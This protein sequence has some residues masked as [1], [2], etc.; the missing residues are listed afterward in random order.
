MCMLTP[1]AAL[2]LVSSRGQ[3]TATH[4]GGRLCGISRRGRSCIGP[5]LQA[6]WL[7]AGPSRGSASVCLQCWE[8]MGAPG[9]WPTLELQP[10]EPPQSA[11]AQQGASHVSG[12][13]RERLVCLVRALG[14]SRL[15]RSGLG[16]VLLVLAV[17]VWSEV[18]STLLFRQFWL[19]A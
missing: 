8:W 12:L 3:V 1:P 6:A 7:S 4:S 11:I 17:P 19:Q 14:G 9:W 16:A 5:V 13:L 10:V 18:V 15:A 2:V